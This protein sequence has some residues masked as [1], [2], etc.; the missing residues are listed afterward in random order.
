M[1]IIASWKM[2][3]KIS[4]S[5]LGQRAARMSSDD[6]EKCSLLT[7]LVNGICILNKSWL[8]AGRTVMFSD[9]RA[10]HQ[11]LNVYKYIHSLLDNKNNVRVVCL[12]ATDYLN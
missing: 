11:Q 12:K 8:L 1:Q 9:E 5:G 2:W 3:L 6:R 4:N 10:F 7:K